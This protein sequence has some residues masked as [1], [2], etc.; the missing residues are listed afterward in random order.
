LIP[1]KD[2]DVSPYERPLTDSE[3]EEF[4]SDFS[5]Y[6]SKAFSLPFVN[7]AQIIPGTKR[8]VP[9]LSRLDS[10]ILRTIKPLNY[11]ASVR[12]IELVK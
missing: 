5:S 3:L 9:S 10:K 4:A 7:A 11:Y 12:V 8:F 6:K 2:P 1:Y